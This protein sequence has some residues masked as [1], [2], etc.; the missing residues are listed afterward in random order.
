MAASRWSDSGP[1]NRL[2]QKPVSLFFS[3]SLLPWLVYLPKVL[4]RRTWAHS[5][6]LKMERDGCFRAGQGKTKER[7]GTVA[8]RRAT[9]RV[10][11]RGS[12]AA[13]PQ[14]RGRMADGCSRLF[15]GFDVPPFLYISASLSA[16]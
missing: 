9:T 13:G 15:D 14:G 3:L 10:C 2:L 16:S 8:G 5:N 1:G 12:V 11:G 6:V 7:R 4:P